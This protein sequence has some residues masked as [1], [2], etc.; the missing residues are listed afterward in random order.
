MAHAISCLH[1]T[2]V[3][4]ITSG[5]TNHCN[6]T[7]ETPLVMKENTAKKKCLPH[8]EPSIHTMKNIKVIFKRNG[9]YLFNSYKPRQDIP[10]L[11]QLPTSLFLMQRN[12]I[13]DSKMFLPWKTYWQC[14]QC[15]KAKTSFKCKVPYS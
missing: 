7:T 1:H 3:V 5:F 6:T 15:R 10:S 12:K 9:L 11:S 2:L 13:I 8:T 14:L 4:T